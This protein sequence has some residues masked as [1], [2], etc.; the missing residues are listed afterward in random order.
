[1]FYI[2]MNSVFSLFNTFPKLGEVK[3]NI[4]VSQPET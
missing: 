1:M 4:K 2:H 3:Q